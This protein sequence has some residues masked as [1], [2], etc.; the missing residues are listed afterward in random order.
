MQ[1]WLLLVLGRRGFAACSSPPLQHNATKEVW[2]WSGGPGGYSSKP[3]FVYDLNGAYWDLTHL[4]PEVVCTYPRLYQWNVLAMVLERT[5]LWL[6]CFWVLSLCLIAVIMVGWISRVCWPAGPILS[7]VVNLSLSVTTN[8]S[9]TTAFLCH[10]VYCRSPRRLYCPFPVDTFVQSTL[11]NSCYRLVLPSVTQWQHKVHFT[12]VSIMHL[13]FHVLLLRIWFDYVGALLPGLRGSRGIHF[14]CIVTSMLQTGSQQVSNCLEIL[15]SLDT[16]NE[17]H[18]NKV[19]RCLAAK[20][21]MIVY[22]RWCYRQNRYSFR[23]D[24]VR[25]RVFFKCIFRPFR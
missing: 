15:T 25:C 16:S 8:K 6:L 20:D 4:Y 9:P 23:P 5:D 19:A 3:A 17:A 22:L 12:S 7:M 24:S 11:H 10:H 18:V 2:N 13:F 14:P 1:T 21:I